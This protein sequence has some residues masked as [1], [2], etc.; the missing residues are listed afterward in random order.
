LLAWNRLIL[1]DGR[2][3]VL[4]REPASDPSGFA[5]LEDKVDFHWGGVLKAALVSTLL[6]AGAELGTGSDDRLLSALRRGT[7]D[8]VGKAGEQV[9]SRELGIRPTLTIRPGFPV[10]V[11]VTRDLVLETAP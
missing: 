11:L 6:G 3:L 9:V 10:R 5:G 2:S 7:Q 1:P 8:S 4:E